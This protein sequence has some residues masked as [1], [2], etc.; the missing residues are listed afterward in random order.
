MRRWQG[1]RST[2][3]GRNGSGK[4]AAGAAVGHDFLDAQGERRKDTKAQARG[5]IAEAGYNT[6]GIALLG[7]GHR[8]V[9]GDPRGNKRRRAECKAN[10][11]AGV[12]EVI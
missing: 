2:P 9:A 5:R 10:V 8:G 4:V 12:Q 6:D 7:R 1:T 11:T 3:D